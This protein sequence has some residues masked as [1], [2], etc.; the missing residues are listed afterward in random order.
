MKTEASQY[1]TLRTYPYQNAFHPKIKSE[2]A[3]YADAE[4]FDK[5]SREKL[6]LQLS[7]Q[8]GTRN[9]RMVETQSETFLGYDTVSF[10]IR[11]K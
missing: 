1:Q 9:P 6:G 11:C 4:I 5:P 3:E 8:E 7:R 2:E 10:M